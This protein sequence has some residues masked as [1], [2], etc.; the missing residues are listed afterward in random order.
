M[1][2]LE[3]F[4][5][6]SYLLTSGFPR[7]EHGEQTRSMGVKLILSMYLQRPDKTLG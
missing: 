4:E 3:I 1:S 6:T 2:K 5:I 7:A